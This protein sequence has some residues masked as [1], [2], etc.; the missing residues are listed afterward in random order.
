[1]D[2]RREPA[3][4]AMRTIAGRCARVL[5]RIDAAGRDGSGRLNGGPMLDR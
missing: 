3:A 1:M 5:L 4:H 2:A